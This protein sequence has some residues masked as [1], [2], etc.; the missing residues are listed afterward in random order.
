MDK[1]RIEEIK[2]E[3]EELKDKKEALEDGDEYDAYDD[4]LDDMQEPYKIGVCEFYPSQILK[5]CDPI[6]YNC[7]YNDFIDSE[8]SD[9]EYR[10]DE[11]E[12]ELKEEE[13]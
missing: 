8:L 10:I 12:E 7:G 1:E 3:L 6:A 5:E 11:L 9:I 13:Q 4:W 2:E